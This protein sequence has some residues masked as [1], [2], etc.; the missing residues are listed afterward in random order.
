MNTFSDGV[1]LFLL[2][3]PP[4]LSYARY[5][6]RSGRHHDNLANPHALVFL[7][8]TYAVGFILLSVA[9]LS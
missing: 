4:Y 6:A 9:K 8:G 1:F 5:R 7:R 2:F 3:L